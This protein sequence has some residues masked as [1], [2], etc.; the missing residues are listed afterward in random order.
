MLAPAHLLSLKQGDTLLPALQPV[1]LSFFQSRPRALATLATSLVLPAQ[2]PMQGPPLTC[3]LTQR[4]GPSLCD[5]PPYMQD[6]PVPS[7]DIA[8]RSASQV[9]PLP[10]A[11]CVKPSPRSLPPSLHRP[12]EG[13]AARA[14]G[15]QTRKLGMQSP[16][17]LAKVTGLTGGRRGETS[18]LA[19]A[20][21]SGYPSAVAG[22]RVP[23][24]HPD[25]PAWLPGTAVPTDVGASQEQVTW[26]NSS[27]SAVCGAVARK[28]LC[29]FCWASVSLAIPSAW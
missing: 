3:H 7:G 18:R 22:G 1:S 4:G 14:T 24:C 10:C 21:A 9:G 11:I 15:L 17:E 6:T 2:P 12:S 27:G 25:Q 20:K 28:L 16:R 5:S 29:S 19:D 26:R 8:H 13:G 23:S